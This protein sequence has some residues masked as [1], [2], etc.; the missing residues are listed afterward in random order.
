MERRRYNRW[1]INRK[2]KIRLERTNRDLP[3]IMHDLNFNGARISLDQRLPY[4]RLVKIKI[5]LSDEFILE[6]KI[7]V[8]WHKQI[9]GKNIYGVYFAK[10]KDSDKKD[11]YK[12]MQ[13]NFPGLANTLR[14]RSPQIS[15]EKGGE[16]EMNEKNF[17]SRRDRRV[18]ERI[19]VR[20]PVRLIDLINNQEIAADTLDVSAKGLGIVSNQALNAGD[21]LEL[22]LSM[23]DRKEPFYTRGSVVWTQPQETGNY[24]AG[25]CLDRA[26]FMGMARVFKA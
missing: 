18:F 24:R 23:P 11:I 3:G 8:V 15:E 1:Q 22:W 6:I 19:S 12:F 14:L 21:A 9:M 5:S 16:G 20:L 13:N 2:I 10:V 26:E 7:W 25:I 4:E 17:D